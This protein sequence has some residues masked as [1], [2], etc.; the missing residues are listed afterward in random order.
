ML[1]APSFFDA[2]GCP[3]QVDEQVVLL[4]RVRNQVRRNLDADRVRVLLGGLLLAPALGLEV[5][6]RLDRL[7]HTV[8]FA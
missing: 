2:Y 4:E 7:A 8:S 6:G 5:D 3:A 1:L